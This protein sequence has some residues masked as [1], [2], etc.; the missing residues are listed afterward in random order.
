MSRLRKIA[1]LVMVFTLVCAYSAW[2]IVNADAT[3]GKRATSTTDSTIITVTPKAHSAIGSAAV[4]L[5]ANKKVGFEVSAIKKCT[6]KVT[7][8]YIEVYKSGKWTKVGD[9]SLP[10]AVTGFTLNASSDA[11]GLIGTG[12]YRV[13]CTY[14]VDGETTTRTSGARTF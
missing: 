4:V 10:K 12:K 13:T 1:A 9:V 11:S 6:I 8:C 5:G 3:E 7:A 14:S 2:G